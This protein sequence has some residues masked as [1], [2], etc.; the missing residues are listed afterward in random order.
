[1]PDRMT[2]T[3]RDVLSQE[4]GSQGATL[5]AIG[6]D[7]TSSRIVHAGP[8]PRLVIREEISQGQDFTIG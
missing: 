5:Y 4:L 6:A 2:R 8:T 3:V 1:M 7:V